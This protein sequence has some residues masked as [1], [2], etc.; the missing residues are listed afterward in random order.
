MQIRQNQRHVVIGPIRSILQGLAIDLD[1]I[2][3][4]ILV[5]A[6]IRPELILE[7]VIC[8]CGNSARIRHRGPVRIEAR[9]LYILHRILIGYARARGCRHRVRKGSV[10]HVH[11]R[12]AFIYVNRPGNGIL[13][14]GIRPFNASCLGQPLGAIGPAHVNGICIAFTIKRHCYGVLLFFRGGLPGAFYHVGGI[15]QRVIA[16]CQ[17]AHIQRDRIAGKFL[18]SERF[19]IVVRAGQGKGGRFLEFESRPHGVGHLNIFRPL[20]HMQ[21]NG[22]VHRTIGVDIFLIFLDSCDFGF[23]Q[24]NG[25]SNA[26]AGEIKVHRLT[27]AGDPLVDFAAEIKGTRQAATA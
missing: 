2:N 15:A 27:F 10:G 13:A 19:H 23:A 3:D 7:A 22:K 18:E 26:I 25:N 17:F 11:P 20:V 24:I 6:G 21:I 12:D 16:S 9:D 8:L 14:I 5:R 4:L 1:R